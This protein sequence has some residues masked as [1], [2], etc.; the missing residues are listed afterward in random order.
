MKLGGIIFLW[1]CSL[2]VNAQGLL[3]EY[4]KA[5]QFW[6]TYNQGYF[7]GNISPQW[8]RNTHCFWYSVKTPGGTY[9]FLTD[10][11]KRLKKAAFDQ[12]KLARALAKEEGR[13]IHPLKLP[14]QKITV[15]DEGKI[16][17][18]ET[19]GVA[20]SYNC[21]SN[22][23]VSK[24]REKPKPEQRYWGQVDRE[25][26]PAAVAS[27]DGKRE[28]YIR[29]GNLFVKEK[30]TGKI[31][32][33]SY[34]GS[35]A[36]YYSSH[37]AWS[38]D[39]KKLVTCK[40]RA[41]PVGKLRLVVS[42]PAGQLLPKMEEVDY[43]RPGDTLPVKKPVLFL[44][45]EGRQV[46]IRFPEPEAQYN[47]GN[48]KWSRSGKYFTF[49]YNKR[50]HQEFI[51]Y[52]VNGNEA[53]AQVLVHE[54]MPTFIHYHRL[55]RYNLE[56]Q[57]EMLW[58]S[59]RDGWRHLYLYDVG[60]GVVKRQLTQGEWIVKQ[61]LHV[62][63]GR[64][65]VYFI[66]CGRQAEEDPYLEKIYSLEID[67][68]DL[69]CLTPENG[70]HQVVFSGDYAYFTDSWSRVDC[71]PVSVLRRTSDGSILM[72]LEK[73]DIS[74]M[75]TDGWQMPEVFAAKG[76]DSVTDI[77]GVIVRPADFDPAKKYPVIE[78][79]Y[80]G[81]HDSFVP[82][83]FSVSPVGWGLTEL[84]FIV[85]QIDG[86]GTANR[87]KKFHDVCWKNLKDA[88]FPDRIAW[89]K[90]A[91]AKYPEMDIERVGIYGGSAGGQNAM[92]AL[93]FHPE[94]YK[95]GVAACGCHDNRMDKIWWNEQ[96]MG[97]PVGKE[98]EESSNSVNAPLLKGKLMLILGE[99][100]NNVDPSSTLQVV[101]GLVKAGREFEFV[102]LPNER[103]TLGGA[104]GERK[105][106]DFFVR[107]LL[108]LEPPV[109]NLIK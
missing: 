47:V 28:A 107:H 45:D 27:G 10:A 97:Y 42:S 2:C 96:W 46:N 85:V 108:G 19:G 22:Q 13:E 48:I 8:V 76:R 90:A 21:E 33:M 77:W 109:W 15:K 4:K 24:R 69:R 88:G 16:I 68:G 75:L 37:I 5:D 99:L 17:K 81:P 91:A 9:F 72:Q 36:E 43:V 20:Y 57:G 61:V 84:G 59:E 79:I 103:H 7:Y 93:L 94:F 66:G 71:P 3:E 53:D 49:D 34:D 100:D 23:I 6:Q 40:Y 29:G 73:A 39:S 82:K 52:K 86:M 1:L 56:E 64:R 25:N 35:A 26:S 11:E 58:I 30:A 74:K 14:F 83:S 60:T 50:G 31:R 67:G 105:R 63:A 89:M 80:A 32:Q 18:F 87:S 102:M 62:D 92:G 65:M 104:Y 101:N 38:P 70:N 41:A 78:Y 106:R 51:V 12:E 98:Y 44:V 54:Q 55:F 95:V